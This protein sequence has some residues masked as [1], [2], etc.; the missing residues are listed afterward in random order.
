MTMITEPENP[1]MASRAPYLWAILV[2]AIAAFAGVVLVLTIRPDKDNAALV[3]QIFGF[4]STTLMATLAYMRS[5]ETREVVN[6]RMDEFKRTL[7]AASAVAQAAAHAAGKIEGRAAADARTD[8]L[9]GEQHR[10]D[11][12]RGGGGIG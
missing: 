1:P 12:E 10:I 3:T 5:T 11:A 4:G 9:A 2:I 7:E 8:S 6:S